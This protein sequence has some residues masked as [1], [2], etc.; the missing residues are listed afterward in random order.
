MEPNSIRICPAQTA[1]PTRIKA[2]KRS[3]Y[4]KTIGICQ[5]K[6]FIDAADGGEVPKKNTA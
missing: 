3:I 5:S 6:D 4:F 1:H 2:G